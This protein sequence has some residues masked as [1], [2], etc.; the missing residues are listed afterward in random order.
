MLLKP[1]LMIYLMGLAEGKLHKSNLSKCEAQ[2]LIKMDQQS[3][4]G[5]NRLSA[6][7]FLK[8]QVFLSES[9]ICNTTN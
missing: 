6:S 8:F 2:Q 3:R 4:I 1:F 7:I 5:Y 9:E